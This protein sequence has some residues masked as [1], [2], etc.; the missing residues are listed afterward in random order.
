[1]IKE[2][3]A[4]G[5]G[6]TA[7]MTVT[8][9]T[10][11]TGQPQTVPARRDPAIGALLGAVIA[12]VACWLMHRALGDDALITVSYRRTLAESGTWGVFPG[13]TANTQTGITDR[14]TD[15]VSRPA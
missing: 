10:V 14:V 13:I 5:V 1:M 6:H 3:E 15:L 11:E 9:R 8:G 12:A 7:R 2:S 4:R